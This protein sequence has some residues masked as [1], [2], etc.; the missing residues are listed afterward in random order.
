[1]ESSRRPPSPRS[2]LTVWTP[3]I[4][5]LLLATPGLGLVRLS[6]AVNIRP[7]LA[8]ILV[9]CAL[10]YLAYRRDKRAAQA[11]AW[12][13]PESTLHLLELCG[14][15]P[16][17][18]F[19]QRILRHKTSK[20]SFLSVYWGIVLLHQFVAWEYLNGWKASRWAMSFLR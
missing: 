19:A 3:V 10:T 12:R 2:R 7:I 16:S 4:L 11:G 8:G 17:A 9:V 18:Y 14:G 5:C 1:M 6:Q 13:V 15:W 20:R